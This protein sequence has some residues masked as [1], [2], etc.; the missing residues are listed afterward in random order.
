MDGYS[1]L[2]YAHFDAQRGCAM[3]SLAPLRQRVVGDRSC[4]GTAPQRV[5]RTTDR[6]ILRIALARHA[7]E[8]IY[9]R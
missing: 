9:G 5:V 6:F 4:T 2:N 3:E 8:R 1:T 7:E